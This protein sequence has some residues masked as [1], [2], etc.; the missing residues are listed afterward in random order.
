M[1]SKDIRGFSH[2]DI[3][4]MRRCF[5]YVLSQHEGNAE[6]MQKAIKNIPRHAYDIHDNCGDFCRYADPVGYEHA[7]IFSP[8][9]T[10]EK[11][12][13]KLFTLFDKLGDN[14][15]KYVHLASTQANESLNNINCHKA[16]KSRCYSK[17]ESADTRFACAVAQKNRRYQYVQDVFQKM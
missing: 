4:Y 11:L 16:P 9:F 7:H 2:D 6:E 12:Q 17:S 1:K 13:K 10:N 3:V 8:N 14:I 15:D 5:S